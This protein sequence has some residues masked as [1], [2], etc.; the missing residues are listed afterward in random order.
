MIYFHNVNIW[1]FY[2]NSLLTSNYLPKQLIDTYLVSSVSQRNSLGIEFF[3]E[4]LKKRMHHILAR[5]LALV[6]TMVTKVDHGN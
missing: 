1:N 4:K 3:N 2:V 6:T 5:F